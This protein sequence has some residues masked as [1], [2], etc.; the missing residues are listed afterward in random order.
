MRET[1][2]LE[3][4]RELSKSYLKTVSA[5][6]NYGTG[7]IVFGV[8]DDGEPLGLEDPR[9]DALRIENAVNDSIVPVP[10]FS[11]EVDEQMRTVTL[12]VK[13]GAAKPY[14]YNGKAYRRADS[15]TV[16]VSRLEHNRLVLAG[17]NT[18]F[19]ALEHAGQELSFEALSKEL[20]GKVGLRS[21]DSNALKSL[22]LMSPD[23]MY[24]NA[25]ALLAD[26]N[27]FPGT[28]IARFGES[29]SIILSRHTFEGTSVL[30]QMSAAM[31]V[32]DEHYTYEEIVG[33][34]RVRKALVP[35]EAFREAL[36]NAIA[37]RAWDVPARIGV[38]MF[39]DRIEVTSPGGL[40][41]GITEDQYLAGGLAVA[42]NPIVANVLFRLGYVERFGTGIPRIIDEYAA[43]DLSPSFEV[44]KSSI[45]VTL[46]VEGATNLTEDERK[47]LSSLPKGRMLTRA[48][49][50]EYG[51]FFQGQDHSF[52]Q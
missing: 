9:A 51:R 7:C 52:A 14:L 26:E 42:R 16:A 4:K 28:D 15:S 44:G 41:D 46:P 3:Y 6:A 13:E 18:S 21:L 11:L 27:D 5:F 32:F 12:L 29:I 1:A 31:S 45:K 24:N 35:R 50:A 40:P 25:A 49:I 8:G 38:S 37:H 2:N 19:D 17:S 48:Q 22:E 34:E 23:G 20:L 30:E 39:V 47:V 33:A 10:D 43:L 36:A